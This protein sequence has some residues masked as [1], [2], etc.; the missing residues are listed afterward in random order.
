MHEC[1]IF[2]FITDLHVLTKAIEVGGKRVF[3]DDNDLPPMSGPLLEECCQPDEI[4]I[5]I[6]ISVKARVPKEKWRLNH[7]LQTVGTQC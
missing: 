2:I 7:I 3:E 6:E 1:R 5:D 4:T